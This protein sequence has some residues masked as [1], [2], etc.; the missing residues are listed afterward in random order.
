M[1][2]IV[3]ILAFYFLFSCS[4][5]DKNPST[6]TDN[7]DKI[8]SYIDDNS[9]LLF[10]N[11]LKGIYA[12]ELSDEQE[13][14]YKAR[15]SYFVAMLNNDESYKITFNKVQSYYYNLFPAN[16]SYLFYWSRESFDSRLF[17]LIKDRFG[18]IAFSID[19]I[20]EY[21]HTMVDLN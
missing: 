3:I 8:I 5:N 19:F 1:K 7:H 6:I 17:S 9:Q 12:L 14:F 21:F 18:N 16:Q 4:T 2:N 11:N 13:V 10:T 20:K 15:L